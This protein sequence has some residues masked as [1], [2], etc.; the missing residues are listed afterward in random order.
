MASVFADF[1]Q[2]QAVGSGHALASCLAPVNTSDN[3]TRLETFCQLSNRQSISADV[4]YY[5]IQDRA[6]T[7]KLPKAEA[8]AWIDI[9]T[10]LWICVRELV[11]LEH[12]TA[13][14]TWAKAFD[15]YK[16]LCNR[17][18]RAYSSDGLQAW[19]IPCLYVTGRYLRAIAIKADAE[20]RLQDS[21]GFS[22]GF[23]EDIMGNSYRNE[24]LEAAAWVINRMFTTCLSDRYVST[25]S[26]VALR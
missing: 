12:G 10:S 4:R 22:N 7:D 17:L 25:D 3:P 19:T 23:S 9:F 26:Q 2:A 21:N 15:A 8:N 20:A 24:K 5:V 16:D 14:A 6:I 1:H 13:G 11:F 18:I